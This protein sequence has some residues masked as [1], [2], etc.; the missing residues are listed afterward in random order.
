M[1]R[2]KALRTIIVK[3]GAFYIVWF[4]V[5]GAVGARIG[6]LASA[7][8]YIKPTE[9]GYI[10]SSSATRTIATLPPYNSSEEEN[11][12]DRDGYAGVWDQLAGCESGG[13]WSINTG[14]GYY[15]GLQFKLSSWQVV[16]G[17]GLP[18]HASKSEQIFRAQ[19]LKDI[20]GW[21]AWPECS[22]RLSLYW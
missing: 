20:Q 3:I 14:N 17:S 21:K 10:V 2:D 1:L 16:G 18:H 5:V 13:D 8:D 12:P 7:D 11:I 15:G 4:L 19:K 22:S 6:S 9:K